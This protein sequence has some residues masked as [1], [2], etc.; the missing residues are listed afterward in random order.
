MQPSSFQSN[1]YSAITDTDN[2]ILINAKAGSGKTTTIVNAL[3]LI[4]STESVIFL[5][6]NRSIVKELQARVP[7]HVIVRTL[8]GNGANELRYHYGRDI[9]VDE[10]KIS[11]IIKKVCTTWDIAEEE[12]ESYCGRVEKLVDIRRFALPQSL[13][14]LL[15]LTMKHGV[16]IMGEEIEH[17]RQVLQ[18]AMKDKKTFDFTD[19]IFVPATFDKR[20]RKFKYVFVDESQ[21]LNRAQQ[22]MLRKIV[23]FENGGRFIAVGDPGQA[24]YGFAG[25]DIDAFANLKKLLPNTIE[26]PLSVCYRCGSNIIS[27]A[28]GVVPEIQAREGAHGGEVRSGSYKEIAPGD[29]VLCRNTR[30]LVSLCLQ[31]IAG[32]K[33]ATIKGRDIGK[34]LINMIKKTKAKSQDVL[35]TKLGV[36]YKKLVDKAKATFPFKDP[37]KVSFVVNFGDKIEALRAIGMECRNGHT[38]EMISTIEKIFTDNVEG[39]VLST[40]HKS[41]GLETDNVFIIER[42]LLP[43][44]YATQEW[45]R[46]QESNLDYVAR[47]RAKNKL[48]YVNDWAVDFDDL[49]RVRATVNEL[50]MEVTA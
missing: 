12:L 35:F 1:I 2:N 50:L 33:K 40:M 7:K 44:S 28:Q 30:P 19:M 26:L 36:E 8:H 49:P 39:I 5:A 6:F 22:T 11:K 14:E 32:G 46:I 48:I 3:S 10:A 37:E 47:T 29:Y 18:L 43:A 20:V 31:F 21:D 13:P 9:V 4:P 24:I 45:E 42:Q 41:K 25:A 27:H 34:N 23:D 15:D 38:D 16:E 17:S